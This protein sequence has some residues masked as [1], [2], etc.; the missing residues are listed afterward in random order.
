MFLPTALL[1]VSSVAAQQWTLSEDYSGATFFDNFNFYDNSDPGNGIAKYVDRGR[2]EYEG[3]ISIT[4]NVVK[5]SAD[6]KGPMRPDQN[7]KSVR[8]HSKNTHDT[9]LFIADIIHMPFG[10]G[11]W[12]ALWSIGPNKGEI[13]IIETV[14][15]LQRNLMNIHGKEGCQ[16]L[17]VEFRNQ[18][19]KVTSTSCYDTDE[20]GP[21]GCSSE[22]TST[23]SA[24]QGFNE[25]KGGVYAWKVTNS[26]ITAWF[27]PRGEIPADISTNT[28]TPDSWPAPVM[29]FPLNCCPFNHFGRRTLIL[30]LTFCGRWA[31]SN[32]E[33]FTVPNGLNVTCPIGTCEA[34][35]RSNPDMI[36][37]AF[38]ELNFIRIYQN[39]AETT[40][41]FLSLFGLF[42]LIFFS[43]SEWNYFVE[44]YDECEWV[45]L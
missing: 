38:W 1:L 21:K 20:A 34:N 25:N 32:Y 27:F 45:C 43:C 30:S 37:E 28:P 29:Y 6:V 31:G 2:A 11:V 39:P 15:L 33:R 40:C 4:N 17:P 23:M 16:S 41:M 8:L 19:A 18:T 14:N 13:D 7:R 22:L 9:G 42:E 36:K 24:G 44:Q 3:M 5:I 10:C 35:V 12:P 26:S